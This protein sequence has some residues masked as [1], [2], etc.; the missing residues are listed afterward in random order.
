MH[1]ILQK[2]KIINFE[3]FKESWDICINVTT[4][5]IGPF[6][7][8]IDRSGSSLITLHIKMLHI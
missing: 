5:G 7:I 2:I 3:R 4:K 6:I 1:K 8:N